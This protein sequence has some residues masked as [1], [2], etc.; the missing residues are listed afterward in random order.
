MNIMRHGYVY[1][2]VKRLKTCFIKEEKMV[3]TLS[4]SEMNTVI[5]AYERGI[6]VPCFRLYVLHED[7][8][9]NID[10]SSDFISGSLSVTY[11][12]GQR[13]TLSVT[14]VN[15]D[16]KYK[17]D[18][19]NSLIWIGTKFRLDAGIVVD[20]VLYWKQQGVF[21]L[22][23]PSR[24][25]EGSQT[26]ISLSLCDKF[27]ML[28]G[29]VY[30]KSSLKTIVPQGVPIRQSF[31][32]ILGSDRGNGK[33]F[34]PKPI[35]FDSNYFDTDT[36][37][38]IKQEAGQNIGDILTELGDSL[39]CDV[40]YD[41]YGIMCV[42]SNQLD[43]IN[44]NFPVAYRINE[45]SRGVSFSTN[46]NWSKMRNK[47]IVKGNIVNGYQFTATVENRNLKSPYCI[48]YNGEISE[49]IEDNAL[50]ADTLCMDRAMYEMIKYSRGVRS[51][52][53]S[54]TFMPLLDVNQSV[55]VTSA[56]YEF[57]NDNFVIDSI[58]MD[59]SAAPRMTLALTN[60]NEVAFV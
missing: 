5:K 4:A 40:Y 2:T 15:K 14:L 41:E 31:Y 23:D 1:D 44:N 27:G 55:L 49:I 18:P 57:N 24:S 33:V 25:R 8:T 11:Q 13:R 30:G 48:Q 59:I 34:D 28:D 46:D 20:G 60:M 47:I 19:I 53:I 42:K 6:V 29:T 9:P 26:T 54:H 17:P 12:S 45:T 52:N 43:F 56:D 38:T 39:A 10:I 21:V 35:H 22:N 51:L 7:E 32:T 37:Y 36:Y 50:Y 16:N 58:S 3:Q